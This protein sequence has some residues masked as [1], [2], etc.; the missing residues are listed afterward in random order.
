MRGALVAC[1]MAVLLCAASSNRLYAEP[2]QPIRLYTLDCCQADFKNMAMFSDTGDYDGQSGTLAVPCFL[3]VHPKG[4][5]LWDTGLS[6]KLAQ[7]EHGADD[8][9]IHMTRRVTLTDQLR[10]LGL[11]PSTIT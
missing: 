6:D 8:N 5:L 4:T 2:V 1:L 10:T 7:N 9:G 11:E 3:I